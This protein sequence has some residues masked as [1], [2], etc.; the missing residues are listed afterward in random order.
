M[1]MRNCVFCE[2]IKT[3]NVIYAGAGVVSFAPLNPVTKGHLLV[4]PIKHIKD[5]TDNETVAGRTMYVASILAKKMGDVN[6]ITSK[7][8]NATQTIKH[9]HIHLVPRRKNDGLKLPWT[10]QI[11]HKE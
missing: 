4:V 5:F 6:L 9:F 1:G 10:N 8:K 11:T 2:K 7:G 3:N